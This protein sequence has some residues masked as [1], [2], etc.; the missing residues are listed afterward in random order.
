MSSEERKNMFWP[1][2]VINHRWRTSLKNQNKLAGNHPIERVKENLSQTFLLTDW[3]IEKRIQKKIT[4]DDP[5]AERTVPYEL[6]FRFLVP[7]L[8]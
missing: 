1:L 6:F 2:E 7:R 8:A 4:I 3:K 5:H